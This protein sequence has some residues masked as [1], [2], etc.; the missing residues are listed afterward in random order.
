[1]LIVAYFSDPASPVAYLGFQKGGAKFLL[2]TSAHTK[3]EAKLRFSNFFIMSKKKFLAKRGAMADFGQGVNTPLYQSI[4][5]Y[6][7]L[8]LQTGT[9]IFILR[10]LI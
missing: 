6:R 7:H 1:M 4:V 8:Y 3:G 10:A 9:N 2:A 5:L